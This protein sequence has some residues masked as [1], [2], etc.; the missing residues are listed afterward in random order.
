MVIEG[1][2]PGTKSGLQ[3]IRAFFFGLFYDVSIPAGFLTQR[4]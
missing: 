1:G 3:A 4:R 2:N